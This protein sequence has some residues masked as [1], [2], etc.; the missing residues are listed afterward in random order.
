MQKQKMEPT[1]SSSPWP[2]RCRYPP[3]P[4]NQRPKASSSIEELRPASTSAAQR[5]VNQQKVRKPI[6]RKVQGRQ[7]QNVE[8]GAQSEKIK[9]NNMQI[10]NKTIKYATVIFCIN[11]QAATWA[12]NIRYIHMYIV[13]CLMSPGECRRVFECSLDGIKKSTRGSKMFS[14]SIFQYF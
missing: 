9:W 4:T 13:R 12:S 1:H 8:I 10:L 5:S 14:S 7:E 6:D 2:S 11:C 3:D